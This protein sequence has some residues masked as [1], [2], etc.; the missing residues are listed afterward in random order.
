MYRNAGR[1]KVWTKRLSEL[2]NVVL[3]DITSRVRGLQEIPRI[4]ASSRQLEP[5]MNIPPRGG[6]CNGA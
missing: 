3:A 4:S 6:M 2:G 1:S 5:Q